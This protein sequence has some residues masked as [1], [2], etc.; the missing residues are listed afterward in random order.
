MTLETGLQQGSLRGEAVFGYS[1]DAKGDIREYQRI[2]GHGFFSADNWLKRNSLGCFPGNGEPVYLFN[3]TNNVLCNVRLKQ[4]QIYEHD[5]KDV[6]MDSQIRIQYQPRNR[7][8]PCELRTALEG[9]G[10]E[11]TDVS[12]QQA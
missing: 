1:C 2:Q 12:R 11:E 8:I 5:G 4:F 10:F 6:V 3:G 9:L 7:G